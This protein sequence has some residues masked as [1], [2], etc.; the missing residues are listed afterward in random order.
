M[1]RYQLFLDEKRSSL[2][3]RHFFKFQMEDGQG[4]VRDL[5]TKCWTKKNV[6]SSPDKILPLGT[7]AAEKSGD[8]KVQ[9]LDDDAKEGHVDRKSFYQRVEEKDGVVGPLWRRIHNRGSGW[10]CTGAVPLQRRRIRCGIQIDQWRSMEFLRLLNVRED[11]ELEN[12]DLMNWTRQ[13]S[14]RI[15]QEVLDDV[16]GSN[17]NTKSILTK[18]H[19]FI[20]RERSRHVRRYLGVLQAVVSGRFPK[21][22]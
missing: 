1:S 9:Y 15:C 10:G 14:G 2:Y 19:G 3:G 7:N 13:A 16:E 18:S 22:D 17:A 6:R 12:E 8:K 21:M 20:G 5:C 11:S 4:Y